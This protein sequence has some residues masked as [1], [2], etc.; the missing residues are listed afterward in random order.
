M[1]D[2]KDIPRLP[3]G[4]QLRPSYPF[5]CPGCQAPLFAEPSI[6]ML[7]GVNS[8]GGH[9][10]NCGTHVHLEINDQNTA[11]TAQLWE[12]WH[13]EFMKQNKEVANP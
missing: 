5:T 10:L 13:K 11:M 4:L 8:G 6:L 1:V 9:C 7:I 12:E 2:A 3:D